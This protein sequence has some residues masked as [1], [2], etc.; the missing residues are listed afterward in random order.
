MPTG[1]LSWLIRYPCILVLVWFGAV[2]IV[3]YPTRDEVSSDQGVG[4]HFDA[5]F[6]TFVS[7][8][9]NQ[10][11]QTLHRHSKHYHLRNRRTAPARR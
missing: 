10:F 1:G 4:P 11:I 2:Q 8:G 3:K 7:P 9:P 5:G 6:L